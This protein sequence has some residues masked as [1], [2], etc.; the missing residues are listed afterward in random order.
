M[1]P[2]LTINREWEEKT[3][4]CHCFL[5][6]KNFPEISENFTNWER[7]MKGKHNCEGGGGRKKEKRNKKLNFESNKVGV[8]ITRDQK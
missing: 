4:N 6:E 3:H 8:N 7:D 5:R 1:G 2:A